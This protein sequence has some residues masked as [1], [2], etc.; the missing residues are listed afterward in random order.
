MYRQFRPSR[1]TEKRFSMRLEINSEWIAI[2]NEIW[3]LKTS[4]TNC[5]NTSN[6]SKTIS[7]AFKSLKN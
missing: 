1:I 7:I 5:S 2:Q 4:E 6:T 3:V